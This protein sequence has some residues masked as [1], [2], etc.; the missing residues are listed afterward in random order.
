M[1]FKEIIDFSQNLQTL[2]SPLNM[3][4]LPHI[5]I[6]YTCGCYLSLNF[7]ENKQIIDE[8][9]QRYLSKPNDEKDALI[10]FIYNATYNFYY[11]DSTTLSYVFYSNTIQ[12]GATPYKLK[13]EITIE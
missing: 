1:T 10:N 8:T 11:F 4:I 13:I 5:T 9:M 7:D 12:L 2:H 6:T 3:R